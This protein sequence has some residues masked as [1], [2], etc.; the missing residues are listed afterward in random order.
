MPV[1]ALSIVGILLG[2]LVFAFV[3]SLWGGSIAGANQADA[4]GS[5]AVDGAQGPTGPAGPA[6][7]TGSDGADGAD[8]VDGVVGPI[9]PRGFTGATGATGVDGLQG[10]TGLTGPRGLPGTSGEKG[11]DGLD[12]A[13]GADGPRSY[14]V[15]ASDINR[16]LGSNTGVE[17]LSLSSLS[18]GTWMITASASEVSAPSSEFYCYLGGGDFQGYYDGFNFTEVWTL[19]GPSEVRYSCANISPV[20]NTITMD[21]LYLTAIEITE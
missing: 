10:D 5:I 16:T 4:A 20:D 7:P 6:G 11:E 8:G 12:G 14:A 1:K 19:T 21:N 3:G 2:A 18:A 9:G 17:L 13:D 15:R